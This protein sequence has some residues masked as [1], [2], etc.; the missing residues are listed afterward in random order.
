MKNVKYVF[1]NTVAGQPLG[2]LPVCDCMQKLALLALQGDI[3]L[4]AKV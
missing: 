2:G 3:R 4:R 1:S